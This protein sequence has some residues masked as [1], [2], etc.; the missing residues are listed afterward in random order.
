[1]SDL[2]SWQPMEYSPMGSTQSQPNYFNNMWGAVAAAGASL[3]GNLLGSGSSKSTNKTNLKIAQMNNDF[4]REMFNRQIEYN[5]D[6]WNA[7]N[8]YNTASA[9]RKRLEDAGLNPYLMLDGGNA[10]VAEGGNGVTPPS[11]QGVTMQPFTP[12]TS[13]IVQ[14]ALQLDNLSFLQD[15]QYQK[16]RIAEQTADQLEADNTYKSEKAML[17]LLKMMHEEKDMFYKAGITKNELEFLTETFYHR[18]SQEY[19]KDLSL[20]KDVDVKQSAIAL[21]RVQKTLFEHQIASLFAI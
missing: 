21:N 7:Q 18:V 2:G 9:Q 11:A 4:N 19:S 14:A 5:W 1:M 16:A 20:Q 10:G 15:E 6:M 17:N 12:D 8:E 3:L 13:G